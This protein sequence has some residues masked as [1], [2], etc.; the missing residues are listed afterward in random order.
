[1]TSDPDGYGFSHIIIDEVHERDRFSDFLL[2]L[3]KQVLPR[4][5]ELRVMLMSATI[6]TEKFA[7][8]FGG[9]PTL[10]IQGRLHPVK[11]VFLDQTLLLTRI[12][13]SSLE[14]VLYD[15]S[16]SMCGSTAFTSAQDFGIHMATCF[17]AEETQEDLPVVLPLGSVGDRV[18]KKLA[19]YKDVSSEKIQQIVETYQQGT[20][21]TV[22]VDT[23]LVV[24]ILLHLEHAEYGP[25]A[26]LVF[27]PGWE[28]ICELESILSMHP[29]FSNKAKYHVYPL[30][31][32]IPSRDQRK[33][34]QD[35]STATCRK[36]VLSTNIA[37]TSLTIDDVVFVIDSGLAKIKS[38][39][40][41]MKISTLQTQWISQASALQRRGRAGRV[42]PGVCFHL[43]S[44]KRHEVMEVHH[45]PEL[46][47]TP[48]EEL[49]LQVK[50]VAPQ[51]SIAEF[52]RAAPDPPKLEAV[53]TAL[54]RLMD[55][56]ALDSYEQLTELGFKLAQL[57]MD[58]SMGK[59]L[60]MG[61]MFGCFDPIVRISTA[62]TY[63]DPFILPTGSQQRSEAKKA[64]HALCPKL[65]RK[66]KHAV[67]KSDPLVIASA[68]SEY[69]RLLPNPSSFCYRHFLSQPIL[70]TLCTMEQQLFREVT[71]LGYSQHCNG[72]NR[73][74]MYNGVTLAVLAAGQYPN[75]VYRMVGDRN[76][77][78]FDKHKVRVH[79]SSVSLLLQEGQRDNRSISAQRREWLTFSEMVMN[80]KH[81][82]VYES[83]FVTDF[84][85]LTLI[86][87]DETIENVKEMEQHHVDFIIDGWIRYRI[88]RQLAIHLYVIRQR[89][90]AALVA[91]TADPTRRHVPQIFQ[92]IQLISK[93][94]E[95]D[96][97][98][99]VTWVG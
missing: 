4:R 45:L 94:A 3:L 73:N 92:L 77:T 85:V 18:E 79:P 44:K 37:E 28:E 21:M 76:Y 14:A 50:L 19:L 2:I 9:C 6:Q 74:A 55:I 57:P 34:F 86:G 66:R 43:F 69:S 88:E 23:K 32:S 96:L 16:C 46:L 38:Y 31:S 51:R 47:R 48:L 90:R 17:G 68:I 49:A 78:T 89:I 67:I 42:Q 81:R 95:L 75:L 36:I 54:T 80:N 84:V 11:P 91:H 12:Q 15:F 59:T 71:R 26:V 70:S 60:I 22:G 24:D 97:E 10:E 39:D 20:F 98:R 29:T 30:H 53:S 8:F 65:R 99:K 62:T 1:M 40:I 64:R 56:D 63:R 13:P 5:P 27:L 35:K 61:H 83:S 93:C 58:P 52:L 7:E 82:M 33:I 41:H 25:G 72:V 87:R